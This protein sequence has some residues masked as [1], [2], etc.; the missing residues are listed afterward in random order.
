[1]E[2]SRQVILD[3][4]FHFIGLG[5]DIQKARKAGPLTFE[6][7][8]QLRRIRLVLNTIDVY[9]LDP[10]IKGPFEELMAIFRDVVP[11]PHTL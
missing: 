8:Q 2:D 11:E 4:L 10:A 9:A 5:K 3:L 1:M 6:H 7:K